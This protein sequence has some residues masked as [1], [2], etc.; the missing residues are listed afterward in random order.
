[1]VIH[2]VLLHISIFG[3]FF[4]IFGLLAINPLC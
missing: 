4:S 3:L 2:T 1:M